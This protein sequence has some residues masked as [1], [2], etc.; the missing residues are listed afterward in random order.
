MKIIRFLNMNKIPLFKKTDLLIIS[1]C[2]LVALIAFLP[3]FL[4]ADED[5]TAVI[6][7]DG[8]TVTEITLTEQTDETIEINSTVIIAEGKSIYFKE[9][10]CPDNTC[11]R[12]G[13]LDSAGE[14]AACIPNRVSVY[15]KS[16][17]DI[18]I[19]AY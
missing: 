4:S 6:I 9:S 15:I 7:S 19:M 2:L 10:D 3:S 18:D 12:T 1:V 16:G 14:S 5:L 11:V 17:N 13:K 8:E